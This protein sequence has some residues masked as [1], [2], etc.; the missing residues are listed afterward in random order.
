MTKIAKVLIILLG[1]VLFSTVNLL[2]VKKSFSFSKS[3]DDEMDNSAFD[4]DLAEEDK[5]DESLKENR[6]YRDYNSEVEV[7]SEELL[8]KVKDDL[9]GED[10]SYKFD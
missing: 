6:P 4:D 2:K 10:I 5:M 8:N 1:L 3:M 7:D 9:R